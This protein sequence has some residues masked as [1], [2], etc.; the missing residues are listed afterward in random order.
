V[1][2]KRTEGDCLR[3]LPHHSIAADQG[4]SRVPGVDGYREVEGGDDTDDTEWMPGLHESVAR[5][6]GRHGQ[7]VE[8]AGLSDGEVANIDH[9]LN[10][11]LSLGHGLTGFCLNQHSQITL[12]LS[13]QLTP[14]F[15]HSAPGRCRDCAPGLESLMGAVDG[16]LNIS[17]LVLWQ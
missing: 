10:L 8:H 9:L 17:C 6:L 5:A 4:Q 16:S 13:Q 14:A 7:A 11:T 15:H 3:R 1:G 12:V 2:T